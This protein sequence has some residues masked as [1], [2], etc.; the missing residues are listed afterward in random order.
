WAHRPGSVPEPASEP[1]TGRWRR[2]RPAPPSGSADTAEW[3]A[4][5]RPARYPELPRRSSPFPKPRRT[6]DAGQWAET[7]DRMVN[8]ALTVWTKSRSGSALAFDDASAL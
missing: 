2:R 1:E 7:A 3:S 6:S 4:T 8:A 5:G